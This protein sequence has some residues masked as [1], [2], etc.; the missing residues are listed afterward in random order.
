[1]QS[2]EPAFGKGL[3]NLVQSAMTS[4]TTLALVEVINALS[5]LSAPVILVLDDYHVI[6]NQ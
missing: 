3:I 6:T 2:V 4:D 5:A 1:M